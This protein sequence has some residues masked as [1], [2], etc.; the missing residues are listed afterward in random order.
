MNVY[1]N[2]TDF[3]ARRAKKELDEYNKSFEES[4]FDSNFKV[5]CSVY[6]A[7]LSFLS[8]VLGCAAF[9]MTNIFAKISMNMF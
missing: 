9:F 8:I 7:K 6:V 4:N 2:I 1:L 5:V 3:D